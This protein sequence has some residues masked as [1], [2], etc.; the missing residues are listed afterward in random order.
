MTQQEQKQPIGI[1]KKFVQ[2][3]PFKD[4]APLLKQFQSTLRT[5]LKMIGDS[6]VAEK[7]FTEINALLSSPGSWEQAYEAEQRLI[8]L[9]PETPL[10]LEIHRRLAEAHGLLADNILEM[11]ENRFNEALHGTQ[12]NLGTDHEIP[13]STSGDAPQKTEEAPDPSDERTG[14]LRVLLHRIVNDLQWQAQKKQETWR[15]K[16]NATFK[17]LLLIIVFLITFLAFFWLFPSPPVDPLLYYLL[18]LNAGALGAQFSLAMRVHRNYG[19]THIRQVK[20]FA[21]FSYLLLRISM[22]AMAALIGSLLVKTGIFS[23]PCLTPPPG[24][25]DPALVG[26]AI[27]GIFFGFSEALVP[28]M[29]S[30]NNG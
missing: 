9:M 26:I 10:V 24:E 13:Q 21:H 25:C 30:N 23:I 29:L 11:Y 19:E 28:N 5:Q 1:W 12:I 22:G 8:F 7:E 18:S 16:R 6:T 17:L 15:N 2:L 20:H 3:S 27:L 4:N 14:M